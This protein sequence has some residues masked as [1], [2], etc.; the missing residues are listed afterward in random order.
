MCISV[1]QVK[2]AN[3]VF[4]PTEEEIEEARKIVELYERALKEGK[5]G[6][7]Y[8]GKFIDQPIYRDAL[9]IL[10]FGF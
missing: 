8:K 2:V 4:S 7:T 5:G 9:N 6:V 3:E 10:R 1:K